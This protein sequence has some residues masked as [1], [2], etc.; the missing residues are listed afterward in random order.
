METLESLVERLAAAVPG[1]EV[2]ILPN[3]SPAQ[4]PSLLVDVAHAVAVARFLREDAACRFDYASNV[5]G[6]DW[7]DQV[8]KEKVRTTRMVEGVERVFE[9]TKEHVEPG[10]LEVVYHLYSM[11]LGHGPLVLRQRTADRGAGARVAS[12][13]PVW[14]SCEFQEREV[15][16][17]FG[18]YFEGHPDLRRI[19]MWDGFTGHPMRR[20]YVEPDDYEYEP[21]PHDQVLEKARR[22][23]P[24]AG[25]KPREGQG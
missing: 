8:V 14:R 20:D 5:T 17:L 1:A 10:Y 4:Q 11:E 3:P 24:A 15:F 13:T 16:D 9:E 23:Y 22:H 19:L 25:G 7:L 2:K 21:T 6:V 18:V 12:L